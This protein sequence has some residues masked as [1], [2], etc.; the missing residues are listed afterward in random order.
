MDALRG[1]A[2]FG[3]FGVNMVSTSGHS[4]GDVENKLLWLGDI[5][6]IFNWL[7]EALV[8]GKFYSIFSLL[9]GIGFGMQLYRNGAVDELRL[10]TFKRR[11]WGLLCIGIAHSLLL[12]VGDILFLYAWLGFV[13]VAFRHKSQAWLLR[14]S[15]ICLAIPVVLY[16][17]RFIH[18]YVSLATPFYWLMM[19]VVPFIGLE[20]LMKMSWIQMHSEPGWGNYFR[21]NGFSFMIRQAD[22]FDQLRPFKVFSMFLLGYWVSRQRWHL[23][24]EDFIETFKKWIVPVFIVAMVLN[25]FM[26]KID[27]GTYYSG[28]W[29]GGLKTL[30]YFVGVVPLSLCYVYLFTKVYISGRFAILETF[31]HVG[32]MALSNY[33]FQSVLYAILFR[34]P[35]LHLYGKLSPMTCLAL[36]LIVFPLQALFSKWWLSQFRYGP[37]EWL[38]RSLTYRTIQP[39]KLKKL[40][41]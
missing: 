35:F 22:L 8:E 6:G 32:R 29:M 39:F 1:F 17:L 12:W 26:A 14:A 5:E 15:L 36:V 33:L 30:L 4:S 37:V 31:T 20:N 27:W 13:L 10:P 3:I 41:V 7:L 21:I 16:P 24:P 28:T 19:E 18:P 11:L 9:F 23:S 2:I 40:H 38:W 34:A 25:L